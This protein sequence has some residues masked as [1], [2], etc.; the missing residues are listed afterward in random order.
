MVFVGNVFRLRLFVFAYANWIIL[1]AYS[2]FRLPKTS[3]NIISSCAL[4]HTLPVYHNN[5]FTG[6]ADLRRTIPVEPDSRSIGVVKLS[7][8]LQRW[9]YYYSSTA[10]LLFTGHSGVVAIRWIIII[11]KPLRSTDTR[12]SFLPYYGYCTEAVGCSAYIYVLS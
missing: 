2:S 11:I 10:E 5:I 7:K 4:W 3:D 8:R 9:K 6:I 1:D 12:L